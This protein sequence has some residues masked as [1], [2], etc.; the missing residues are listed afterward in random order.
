M[1]KTLVFHTSN[2]GS[3]PP[4]LNINR[5]LSLDSYRRTT[6]R[7]ELPTIRYSFRFT[8]LIPPLTISSI[9][10]TEPCNPT[11][12]SDRL[13]FKRSYL[14]V[15]WINYLTR[16]GTQKHKHFRP[17]IA[18]LPAKRTLYTLTKAPMAHKTN[19]KE[20]FLF[21]FYNFKFSFELTSHL[22]AV[23]PNVVN[24]AYVMHLTNQL[25]PVFETNLLSLKYYEVSYP[26]RITEFLNSTT[27]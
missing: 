7:T 22:S 19:S 25:F 8:S 4:G 14:V 6:L 3:I 9:N 27:L 11:L 26:I 10:T 20:Q 16:L 5:T 17:T 15:S 24:G 21:K 23:A 18:I 2:V 13:L 12:K 1:V